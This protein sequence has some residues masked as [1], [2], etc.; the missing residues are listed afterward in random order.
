MKDR[1]G[2][3]AMVALVAASAV[4]V[5]LWSIA[6]PKRR[7]E[8]AR[9]FGAQV[10]LVDGITEMGEGEA[11]IRALH[12][13]LVRGDGGAMVIL[14]ATQMDA[15]ELV[16]TREGQQVAVSC[17]LG[18]QRVVRLPQG[19]WAVVVLPAWLGFLG[20]SCEHGEHHD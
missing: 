15:A 11:R 9:D 6:T 18:K 10:F 2:L 4:V 19:G 7:D 14:A 5:A 17:M 8:V 13:Y 3:L 16:A 20:K 12:P 1:V